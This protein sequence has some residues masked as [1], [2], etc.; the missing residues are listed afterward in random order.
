[1]PIR[2]APAATVAPS[3]RRA[4]PFCLVVFCVARVAMSSLGV[5]VVR[6]HPPDVS[7]ITAFSPPAPFIVPAIPGWHNAVDGM[8][9]WD[10]GWFSWIA[11]D[12]YG[13]GFGGD[14]GARIAFFPAF[15]ALEAAA[16]A[17]TGLSTPAA[18]VVVSNLA[19]LASLIALFLLTAA[20]LGEHNARWSIAFF[21]AMPTSFFLL[22]PY[23]ESLFLLFTLL[24][25]LWA[26]HS[27]WGRTS[28]AAFLAGLTRPIAIALVPALWLLR[29]ERPTSRRVSTLAVVAP[30][31][32][33]ASFLAWWGIARGDP[34]AP[35]RAQKYWGR[36]FVFAPV[37][38][39]RGSTFAVLAAVRDTR[40]DL[41]VDGVLVACIVA[42]AALAVRR[43]PSAYVAYIW[44]SLVIPLSFAWPSRPFLSVPRFACVLFPLAWTWVQILR[45]GARMVAAIA[46]MAAL[47]LALAAI[48][49][50]WG[51]IF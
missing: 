40:P 37:T 10:A 28:G 34:V 1:M 24:A 49:M 20:E 7:G 21:A 15:P 9:R 39:I 45:T 5:A 38:M 4:A 51:W 43:L 11:A 14:A 17:A 26:R 44:T 13:S 12:G 19:Y 23:S 16:A 25:F 35:F 3:L 48:F 22:A 27:R 6:D 8:Q 31:V 29:R 33:V 46:L 47:Q 36:D 18:G 50:N 2:G 42:T 32:G 30:I 41:I